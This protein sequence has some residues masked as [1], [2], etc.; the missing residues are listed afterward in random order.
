MEDG[1]RV[2]DAAFYVRG[3]REE[4]RVTLQAVEGED[5]TWE[6]RYLALDLPGMPTQV[7]VQPVIKPAPRQGWHPFGSWFR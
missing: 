2:L 6:E 4:A 7:L 1:R 5:G 3:S